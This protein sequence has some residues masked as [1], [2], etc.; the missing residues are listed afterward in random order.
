MTPQN[1]KLTYTLGT[2]TRSL[3][4]FIGF[5]KRHGIE[6][7]VDVRRFPSS[8]F[9]YFCGGKLAELLDE[10]GTGRV[11][12]RRLPDLHHYN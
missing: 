1:D 7:V 4:E 2:S 6:M 3:E 10:A 12:Q 9:E 11:P 8:R 5:L